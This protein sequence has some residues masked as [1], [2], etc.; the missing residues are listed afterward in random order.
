MLRFLP[1]SLFWQAVLIFFLALSFRLV[2]LF[3]LGKITDSSHV[4]VEKAAITWAREGRLAD[5][6]GKDTGPT[7]HVPPLYTGLLAGLHRVFDDK[8]DV[9]ENVRCRTA[10]MAQRVLSTIVCALGI[11]LLPWIARRSGLSQ[12]AGVLAG[13]VLAVYP[14]HIFIETYGRQE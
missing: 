12:R 2:Y 8:E 14:Y 6:F 3:G 13:V 10:V 1:R 5:A 9:E 7:A 4:E 11:A